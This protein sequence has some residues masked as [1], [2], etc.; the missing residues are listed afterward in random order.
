MTNQFFHILYHEGIWISHQTA[1]K[2]MRCGYAIG[3][4]S[5]AVIFLLLRD[6]VGKFWK[7][8]LIHIYFEVANLRMGILAWPASH[9]KENGDSFEFA[10]KNLGLTN[11]IAKGFV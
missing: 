2:A 10:Q 1:Q 7:I 11:I 3:E 9:V 5:N 8:S 4:P 6:C